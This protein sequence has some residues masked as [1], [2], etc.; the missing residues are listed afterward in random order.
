MAW[1]GPMC[2]RETASLLAGGVMTR[3]QARRRT[4]SEPLSAQVEVRRLQGAHSKSP[5]ATSK[6]ALARLSHRVT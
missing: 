3:H 6:C 2:A 1:P 4:H 5:R